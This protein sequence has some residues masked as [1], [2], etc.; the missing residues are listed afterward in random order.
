MS[1][2]ATPQWRPASFDEKVLMDAYTTAANKAVESTDSACGTLLTACFSIVTAYGAAIALV[3]PKDE[4]SP[5]VVLTPFVLFAIGAVAAMIGKAASVN[6]DAV[7]TVSD[8]RSRITRVAGKK[9]ICGWVAVGALAIGLV[10]AGYVLNAMFGQPTAEAT[11]NQ[12]ITLTA[13]GAALLAEP[14]GTQLVAV[15]GSAASTNGLTSI[16]LDDPSDC[17]GVE[18]ITVPT[19]SIAYITNVVD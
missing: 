11:A 4:Q 14:C 17:E 15:I 7:A 13:E 1:A 6:L 12:Q 19:G 2:P 16:T 8:T 18:M 5:V 3:A 10:V 9:R